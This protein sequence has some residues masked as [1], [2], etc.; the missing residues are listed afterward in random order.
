DLVAGGGL[1]LEADSITGLNAGDIIEITDTV[2][3]TLREFVTITADDDA[4]FDEDGLLFN[5]PQATTSVTVVTLADD[6]STT[7]GAELAVGSTV[8]VLASS[9]DFSAADVVR[10]ADAIYTVRNMVSTLTLTEALK[11]SHGAGVAVIKQVPMLRVHA[12]YQGQ[13]GN[14]LRARVRHAS[15]LETVVTNQVEVDESVIVL[16]AV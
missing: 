9:T 1:Q 11:A 2:D 5:H 12:R 4:G 13:W 10:I 7:L 3:P 16:D 8:A 14:S 6:A 15:T